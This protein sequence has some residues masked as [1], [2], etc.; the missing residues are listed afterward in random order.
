MHK[1]MKKE[2]VEFVC[3]NCGTGERPHKAHG[4]CSPCYQSQYFAKVRQLNNLSP[5]T[6][7]TKL[8]KETEDVTIES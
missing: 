5:D 7:P 6:Q 8:T 2:F 3:E 4:L 1:M